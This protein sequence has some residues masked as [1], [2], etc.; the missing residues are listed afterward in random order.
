MLTKLVSGRFIL[1]IAAAFVFVWAALSKVLS[2]AEIVAVVMFVFQA[3]F[4][5]ND[6]NT[7]GG[8]NV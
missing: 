1:T 6:R 2:P 8:E 3:Y 5:R 7:K 4:H